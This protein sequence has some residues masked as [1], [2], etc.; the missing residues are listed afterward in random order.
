MVKWRLYSSSWQNLAVQI[1]H[2]PVRKRSNP[3]Q[4]YRQETN[5][6]SSRN[7]NAAKRATIENTQQKGLEAKVRGNMLFVFNAVANGIKNHITGSTDK[8]W[9]GGRRTKEIHL[10]KKDTL[11]KGRRSIWPLKSSSEKCPT[12]KTSL[13]VPNAT[14]VTIADTTLVDVCHAVQDSQIQT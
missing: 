12:Q 3:Q 7:T 5:R 8:S 4:S 11:D 6:E 14:N 13:Y 9:K 10:R 1:S 2:L